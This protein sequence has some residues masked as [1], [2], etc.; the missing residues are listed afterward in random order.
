M[1]GGMALVIAM[2]R[3]GGMGADEEESLRTEEAMGLGRGDIVTDDLDAIALGE[4]LI[5]CFA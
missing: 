4:V 1:R 3:P 2:S 5:G